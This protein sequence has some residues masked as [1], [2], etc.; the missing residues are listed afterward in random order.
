MYQKELPALGGGCWEGLAPTG[1]GEEGGWALTD[2]GELQFFSLNKLTLTGCTPD[3]VMFRFPLILSFSMMFFIPWLWV[4]PLWLLA[5]AFLL[6]AV[7]CK[8]VLWLD[9]PGRRTLLNLL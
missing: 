9:R 8:A 5:I 7:G 2:L 3:I 4:V 1:G 6:V